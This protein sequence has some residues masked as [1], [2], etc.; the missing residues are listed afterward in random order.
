MVVLIHS[1]CGLDHH[2][3]GRSM[4]VGIMIFSIVGDLSFVRDHFHKSLRLL[5]GGLGP[6]LLRMRRIL[7]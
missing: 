2:V 3:R 5:L 6:R 1:M 4:I 7:E